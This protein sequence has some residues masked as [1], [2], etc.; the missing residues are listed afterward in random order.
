MPERVSA[1]A[2]TAAVGSNALGSHATKAVGNTGCIVSLGTRASRPS[3]S[4]DRT[5][6]AGCADPPVRSADAR[7]LP[8][9]RKIA[10]GRV[11]HATGQESFVSKI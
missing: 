3:G 6:H 8:T 4:I 10:S 11:A 5:N 2:S 7:E 9:E 1:V